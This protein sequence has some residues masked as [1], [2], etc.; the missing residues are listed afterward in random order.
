MD[1]KKKCGYRKNINDGPLELPVGTFIKESL[2]TGES[3]DEICTNVLQRALQYDQYI[4]AATDIIHIQADRGDATATILQSFGE[5]QTDGLALVYLE[6][7]LGVLKEMR[8]FLDSNYDDP[9]ISFMGK[10]P[11]NGHS[12]SVLELSYRPMD[13]NLIL[14]VHTDGPLNTHSD[15]EQR[16]AALFGSYTRTPHNPN[17]PISPDPGEIK[18]D[19]RLSPEQILKQ[20]L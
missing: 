20:I 15:V 5:F 2:R 3:I 4:D 6:R 12:G 18:A 7:Y 17:D 8:F 1:H 11:F 10:P 16:L 14:Y 9:I 13:E 19:W